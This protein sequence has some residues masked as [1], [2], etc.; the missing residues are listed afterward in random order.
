MLLLGCGDCWISGIFSIFCQRWFDKTDG[1]SQ[2][3]RLELSTMTIQS[4]FDLTINLLKNNSDAFP[5]VK[6]LI[7]IYASSEME[8]FS[9]SKASAGTTRENV[10][11]TYEIRAGIPGGEG[12]DPLVVGY[13]GLLPGLR[14]AKHEH[15]C[16]SAISSKIGGFFIFSDFERQNLIGVLYSRRTLV[17]SRD[18]LA[19]SK[20][21]MGATRGG[22]SPYG[23][24]GGVFVNGEYA[25]NC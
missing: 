13:D 14:M 22:V 5:I 7:D 9:F 4:R 1:E 6:G 2:D 11:R 25:G 19:E 15:V 20:K 24:S 10:L 16:V 23:N 18:L 17:E 8:F 12:N 3:R 21:M